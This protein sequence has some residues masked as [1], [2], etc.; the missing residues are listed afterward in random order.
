M[1]CAMGLL[2]RDCVRVIVRG[3]YLA[4]GGSNAGI[5]C[6]MQEEGGD[7][8]PEGYHDEEQA[9]CDPRCMPQ[10]RDQGIPDRKVDTVVVE[11]G[12]Y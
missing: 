10:V 2:T 6:E 7:G 11:Q 12:L 4:K 9:P 1:F 8:E 5:L 3:K